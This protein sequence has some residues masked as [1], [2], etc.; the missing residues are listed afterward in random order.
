MDSTS[1]TVTASNRESDQGL[2]A[3]GLNVLDPPS[4][5]LNHFI[6]VYRRKLH[7]Q[8]LPLF[9]SEDIQ[10]WLTASPKFLLWSFLALTLN[11]SSHDFYP[12][13]KESDFSTLYTRSAEESLL[14][15]AVEGTPRVEVVQ[16]LCLL[17]VRHIAGKFVHS[18]VANC[19]NPLS[20]Q[21][22]PHEPG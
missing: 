17:A 16:A 9:N 6:N 7:L 21:S 5:V 12:K 14:S 1:P 8:P 13:D 2:F 20:Q 19:I 10:K 18:H 15:L 3:S 4:S 22:S 11:F